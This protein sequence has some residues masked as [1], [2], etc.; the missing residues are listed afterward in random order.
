MN[1]ASR[2]NIGEPRDAHPKWL[3]LAGPERSAAVH[4]PESGHGRPG[5]NDQKKEAHITTDCRRSRNPGRCG[6]MGAAHRE[7]AGVCVS[8]TEPANDIL[9][10]REVS[11]HAADHIAHERMRSQTVKDDGQCHPRRI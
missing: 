10:L 9:S 6:S 4:G 11:A 5:P 8:M 2:V 3:K 1:T 7:P